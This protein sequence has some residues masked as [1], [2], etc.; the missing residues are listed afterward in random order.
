MFVFAVGCKDKDEPK[1]A[2]YPNVIQM[3][4]T[5]KTSLNDETGLLIYS[6]LPNEKIPEVGDIVWSYP[7]ED[8]PEGYFYKVK[9]INNV[10]GN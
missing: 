1:P 8:T 4:E 9:S 2:V 6:N 7:T 5:T 3:D 10:N